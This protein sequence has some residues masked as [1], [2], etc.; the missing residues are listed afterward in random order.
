MLNK[1]TR[2]NLSSTN[3]TGSLGQTCVQQNH[4]QA[5]CPGPEDKKKHQAQI[6][7]M[8]RKKTRLE[9]SVS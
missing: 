2:L 1:L 8:W 6:I 4:N 3:N 9:M 5:D 7:D